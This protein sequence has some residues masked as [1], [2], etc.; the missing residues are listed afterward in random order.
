MS[1]STTVLEI[2]RLSHVYPTR[3]RAV[4]VLN[5]IS[6][7]VA[8]SSILA[9]RGESGSGKT[10]LLMACGAMQRPTSGVVKLNGQDLFALTARQ[11]ARYRANHIGYLF[12]TLELVPYLNLVD[13]LRM[14]RGVTRL[15]AISWLE[16]LGLG[17]RTSHKPEM[18][19][20]GQ[21]Q[22]AAL[23]RALAHEPALLIADEPTGNLDEKNSQ[24][25]FETMRAYADGGGAVLVATHESRVEEVADQVLE[26]KDG[27]LVS[28]GRE[29]NE[30]HRS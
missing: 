10:T 13:N 3:G 17:E 6:F 30:S 9:V 24:L 4:Q 18:L 20:H 29:T 27:V 8:A 19:S 16:K 14:A 15:C 26:I 25:V 21:R 1:N 2:D 7:E 5:Q 11:R 22:R 28:K 12:Q 23:A